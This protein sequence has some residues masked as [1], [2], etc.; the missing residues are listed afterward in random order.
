MC[1]H[2]TWVL[3]GATRGIGFHLARAAR[4]AG[5]DVSG[6]VRTKAAG[7]RLASA[8]IAAEMLDVADAASIR[9]FAKRLANTS[10]DVLINNAAIGGGANEL[11]LQKTADILRFVEVNTCGALL[12]TRALASNIRNSHCR[13]VVNVSSRM[14][15]IRGTADDEHPCAYAYRISK[16][17]LNMATQ[18]LAREFED[19][20]FLA[21]A[22]RLGSHTTG[23]S[24]CPHIAIGRRRF[25]V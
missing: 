15:S 8:G 9:E 13:L 19:V 2:G 11:R 5:E 7:R 6:T 14:A 16:A 1:V 24:P 22:P 21:L 23:R 18:C 17:A 12:V 3:T 4:S 25:A 10:V 20:T